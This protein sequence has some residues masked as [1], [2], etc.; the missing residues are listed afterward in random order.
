[1][2][3]SKHALRRF[4]EHNP[5]A[6][7][8]V[9]LVAYNHAEPMDRDVVA[10]ITRNTRRQHPSESY[11]LHRTTKDQA[12]IFATTGPVITTYLRLSSQQIEV[13]DQ[14]LKRIGTKQPKPKLPQLQRGDKAKAINKVHS[15]FACLDKKYVWIPQVLKWTNYSRRDSPLLAF[16][17]AA[18]L[19]E[20]PH[21]A[22]TTDV[23]VYRLTKYVVAHIS[24][25]DPPKGFQVT[26]QKAHND[27]RRS[28]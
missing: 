20:E 4:Q 19:T 12:G 14:P 2:I 18:I 21:E 22:S 3:V 11:R 10:A 17:Y 9:V 15:Y 1:M 27:Q 23:L 8:E 26:L 5:D 24:V 13:F 28:P 25:Q 7:W 6:T 16:L